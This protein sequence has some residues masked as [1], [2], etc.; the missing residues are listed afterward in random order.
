MYLTLQN[1]FLTFNTLMYSNLPLHK[2]HCET[3]YFFQKKNPEFQMACNLES[4]RQIL[5]VCLG[6]ICMQTYHRNKL[7]I[8]IIE[9]LARLTAD[10]TLRYTSANE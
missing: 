6:V 5:L 8:V 2:L 9:E 4:S 1:P 10:M 3:S 7:R